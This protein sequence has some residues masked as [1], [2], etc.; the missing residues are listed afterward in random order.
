MK[1]STKNKQSKN[2]SKR[3]GKLSKKDNNST[4]DNFKF[5]SKAELEASR[6]NAY[7]Y[8]I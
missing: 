7:E 8:V 2:N 1:T 3:V 4:Y 6:C 5:V